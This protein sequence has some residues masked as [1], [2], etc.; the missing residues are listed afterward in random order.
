MLTGDTLCRSG[1]WRDRAISK[2]EKGAWTFGGVVGR[3]TRWRGVGA[4]SLRGGPTRRLYLTH[5]IDLT[6]FSTHPPSHPSTPTL[7]YGSIAQ[8]LIAGFSRLA[9]TTCCLEGSKM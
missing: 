8:A 1:L 6:D 4:R 2:D 9:V 5:L 7:L 3:V